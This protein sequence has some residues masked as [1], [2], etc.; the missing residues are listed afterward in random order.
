[1]HKCNAKIFEEPIIQLLSFECDDVITASGGLTPDS[2]K[3]I[4][5]FDWNDLI[6]NNSSGVHIID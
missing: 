3:Q 1:M 2:D 5:I 6:G 4:E